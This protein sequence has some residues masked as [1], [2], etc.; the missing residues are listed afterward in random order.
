[1]VTLSI[2]HGNCPMSAKGY[3]SF[4]V[5]LSGI[6][7]NLRDGDRFGKLGVDL[8]ERLND[9]TV[10]SACHFTWAAFASPWV[11]PIDE[12]IAV[13]RDGVRWGLQS[14]DH[15][16]VGYCAARGVT[17]L[18][19]R[20]M[21]LKAAIVAS[22]DARQILERTRDVTNVSLLSSRRRLAEWLRGDGVRHSLDADG[23]SEAALLA[24]LEAASVSKSMLSHLQSI[25]LMHRYFA[26]E[27]RDA[28]RISLR[29]DEL[30]VYST[31]MLT[32]AEH[33]FFQSLVMTGLWLQST[34]EERADFATRLHA[35]E[36]RLRTWAASCPANFAALLHCVMGEM[37]RIHGDAFASQE[38]FDQAMADAHES[39]FT[40]IEAI[41]SELAMKA[42]AAT[43]PSR[44]ALMRMRALQAYESWGATRK[45]LELRSRGA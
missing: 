7:G 39:G 1:M 4:A 17:H 24:E 2:E 25:L 18:F 22:D 42:C 40:N 16:H 30:L 38:C 13:F 3:G 28:W 36:Q 23:F 14:G 33:V 9:I 29:S 11:R 41:A 10:R 12:S 19:F 34:A 6:V 44:A 35:N 21:P 32:I 45:V 5:I 37:A 15:A 27:L 20:G 8:C 31:G 26:G 43:D